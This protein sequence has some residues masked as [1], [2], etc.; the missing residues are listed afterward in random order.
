MLVSP[1]VN[2]LQ[3]EAQCFCAP[4]HFDHFSI[5]G[6]SYFNVDPIENVE[7]EAI[8]RDGSPHKIV[9]DEQPPIPFDLFQV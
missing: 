2:R 4:P 5:R 7:L 8:A 6:P 9:E 1:L 3:A